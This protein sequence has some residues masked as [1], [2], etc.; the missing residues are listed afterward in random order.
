[1]R[2]LSE[3]NRESFNPDHVVALAHSG[4][5][6]WTDFLA[7]ID[8]LR[9]RLSHLESDEV[10]LFDND[11]YRFGAAML[12]LLA[13]GKRIFLP[14][15]NHQAMASTLESQSITLVG[16]WPERNTIALDENPATAPANPIQLSGLVTVYTSG[17][18]GTPK[19]IDK[20][21]AQI[22]A[23]LLALEAC[24]GSDIA[25]SDV[26]SGVSHQHLYG[27]LF[28]FCW[29]LSSGR[30]FWRHPFIDPSILART[31]NQ[32]SEAIWISSPG[33][34]HRLGQDLP[35][36]Q[37]RQA[38]R[39]V[40]SS[41][42]PLNTIAAQEVFEGLG[43]Y[44]HEVLGSSETGGI[45]HRQQREPGTPWTPLP[46]VKIA[47]SETGNLQVR[48]PFLPGDD[49][50]E[51]GDILLEVT[52]EGFHLGKRSDRIAKIEGKR[53]SLVEVEST[54]ES[55]PFIHEAYA[56]VVERHRE[57]VGALLSLSDE[58][59]AA[60]TELG[61]ARFNK[62]LRQAAIP[63]LPPL[64]VPRVWRF[65]PGLPRNTQGKLGADSLTPWFEDDRL[66]PAVA[67][68]T[69]ENGCTLKVWVDQNC[70]YFEGHFP[71][72]P[73]LPGVV[74]VTWAEAYA[75]R[76]LDISGTFAGMQALK[77]KEI[78][79]PNSMLDLE[80]D[81]DTGRGGLE[82]RFSS[83]GKVHSQGRLLF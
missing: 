79:R 66:P 36:D 62:T 21:L 70:R 19:A 71:Q 38:T 24:F 77:F 54:L 56:L 31:A 37:A 39:A 35:W 50:F 53:I 22:D 26:Y 68:T 2:L 82:F 30:A 48:S 57:V 81:W 23:E 49:W 18:T 20:T 32:S 4:A 73:V 10:A 58:G 9:A 11:T 40:F 61:L 76:H 34:L 55:H 5:L 3:L 67:Q 60:I 42:G 25:D 75:R 29:P 47:A 72:G 13:E 7:E 14:G 59:I 12:A 8:C 52:S 44:P 83:A 28:G 45:A 15:E 74:Q 78:V 17:S 65:C 33:H 46:C 27:L 51:T 16:N 43:D 80:L 69:R 1:M 64:G 41:G 6:N 63:S